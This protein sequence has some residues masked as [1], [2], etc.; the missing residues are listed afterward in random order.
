MQVQIILN[1]KLYEEFLKVEFIN[2]VSLSNGNTQ[3]KPGHTNAAFLLKENSRLEIKT[4]DRL[5]KFNVNSKD[6]LFDIN[7]NGAIL[8][9]NNIYLI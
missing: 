8:M 7:P 9:V 1:D 5:L 2:F 3:I 6:A 4:T